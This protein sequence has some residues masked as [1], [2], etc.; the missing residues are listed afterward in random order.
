MN[1]GFTLIELLAVIIILSIIATITVFTTGNILQETKE[2]LSETQKKNLIEAAK[3]YYL[4]NSNVDYVCVK[5]LIAEDFIEA[6]KVYD[7]KNREE[8]KGYITITESG[9]KTVYEYS[10]DDLSICE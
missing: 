7:P 2:S 8:I 6:E 3:H 1:K 10:E 9:N 4:L 5:T